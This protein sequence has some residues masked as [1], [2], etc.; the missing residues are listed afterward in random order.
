MAD[1]LS[2]WLTKQD[3]RDQKK[4]VMAASSVKIILMCKS[5]SHKSEKLIE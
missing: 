2:L 5:L 4:H 1:N 3:L